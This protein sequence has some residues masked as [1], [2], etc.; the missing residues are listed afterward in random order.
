M[1]SVFVGRK[2]F[3]EEFWSQYGKMQSNK[4][5]VLNYYG[6]GGV[7]KSSLLDQLV[8]EIDHKKLSYGSIFRDVHVLYHD[9]ANGIN[10]RQILRQWRAELSKVGAEFP[11]FETGDF[12]LLLKEGAQNLDKPRMK[13]W[14]EDSR[15]IN[16]VVHVMDNG[17]VLNERTISDV[18][19][20]LT[21]LDFHPDKEVLDILAELTGIKVAAVLFRVIDEAL[22]LRKTEMHLKEHS[23]VKAELDRRAAQ[24]NPNELETFL[25]ILFAQ[26]LLDW[27]GNKKLI[28]FLDTYEELIKEGSG[29]NRVAKNNIRFDEW[30]F[31][32]TDGLVSLIPNSFWVIGGR[33][34]INRELVVEDNQCLLSGFDR[35]ES[36]EFLIQAGIDD[37][38]Y[39]D[40][41][42]N[43]TGGYP[44]FLE[45]CVE[46]LRKAVTRPPI[47]VLGRHCR[48][49]VFNRLLK[50]IIDDSGALSMLQGLCISGKWTVEMARRIVPHFNP[51]THKKI[52][53]LSF[54]RAEVATLDGRE[55]EIFYIDD[56][57][58]QVLFDQIFDDEELSG[59]IED[60]I[61]LMAQFEDELI[62][63][64]REEA[65]VR[66][67]RR[68]VEL[69][70]KFGIDIE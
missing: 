52:K 22:A 38:E 3:R 45:E 42:I 8:H 65:A 11:Y 64:G 47:D 31:N 36:N 51:N 63:E 16:G 66:L 69:C 10:T 43:L 33:D 61:V 30:L 46:A 24:H 27:L 29:G 19:D 12:F 37:R 6:A 70:R 5:I 25:P 35:D 23:D 18:N 13:S 44:I 1:K 4:P 2:N 67:D 60:V 28:I 48:K 62:D 14:L 55:I 59:T 26:D 57:I 68:L 41:I 34:K 15:F 54:I 7:G 49:R 58:Q 9:F 17:E 32:P 50:N 56:M 21:A 20:K 39:R 40:G 53:N